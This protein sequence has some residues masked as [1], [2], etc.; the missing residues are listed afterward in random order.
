MNFY[1]DTSKIKKVNKKTNWIDNL[2]VEIQ[3][4]Y[5]DKSGFFIIENYFKSNRKLLLRNSTCGGLFLISA[6]HLFNGKIKRLVYTEAYYYKYKIGD[7][8]Q[9]KESFIEIVGRRIK[10]SIKIYT[11]KQGDKL[12]DI[13][14]NEIKNL[15][16]LYKI[17][18]NPISKTHKD[19]VKYFVNKSDSDKYSYGSNKRV[20]VKC[21]DCGF[22]KSQTVNKLQSRGFSCPICSDGLSYP[23]KIM[24]SFLKNNNIN[25]ISEVSFDWSNKKRYDFYIP[26]N[27]II[28]EVHGLQHYQDVNGYMSSFKEQSLNDRL[29]KDLCKLNLNAKYYEINCSF[30]TIEWISKEIEV[31]G[32]LREFDLNEN[33]I[34]WKEIESQAQKSKMKEACDIWNFQ[35]LHIGKIS[36]ILGVSTSTVRG[37]LKKGVELGICDY[38]KSESKSRSGL[39]RVVRV[40]K[41]KPPKLRCI[42]LDLQ[43]SSYVDCADYL[44]TLFGEKFNQS[45]ISSC[46]RGKRKTHKK[47]HFENL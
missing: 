37:Y 45:H 28:I 13:S 22:E 23:N 46:C 43:F 19:L 26:E 30:S 7:V 44:E 1:I 33:Y 35:K 18:E 34:N 20:Q 47:L 2:G 3:Y 4:K 32:L 14:Q 5:K 36:E 11:I 8:L 40:K 17:E 16:C 39:V 9:T 27:N 25:F 38:S 12:Y 21:P 41:T 24:A 10:N 31:S 6:G 42:E 29:K 15:T